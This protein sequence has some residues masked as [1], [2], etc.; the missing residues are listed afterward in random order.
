MSVPRTNIVLI[1]FM[2]SGK[3]SVGR[4]IAAQLGFQFVDTDALLV[5]REGREIAE[6]F[7]SEGEDHFRDLESAMLE[8]LATRT[9]CVISTGGGVILREKNRALLRQLGLVVWLTASEDTIFARVSRTNKRPL[10][11]TANPR[12]TVTE[13]F[14]ARRPLYEAAAQFTLDTTAFSH[15]QAA[16]AVIAEARR[17]FSWDTAG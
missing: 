7:A 11:Q 14:A 3:S 6:I 13:L 5:E 2:G 16:A 8:A 10:L 12:A 17:V 1:G 4:R 9:G 15:A